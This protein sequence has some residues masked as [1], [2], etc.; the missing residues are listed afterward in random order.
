MESPATTQAADTGRDG[1]RPRPGPI[2]PGERA[3]R[4]ERDVPNRRRRGAPVRAHRVRGR[5]DALPAPAPAQRQS[6]ATERAE[7][8]SRIL[9]SLSRPSRST[10]ISTETLS[11]ESRFTTLGRG[12][13]S[14]PGSSTTSLGSPRIVVVHGAM[15]VRPRRGMAASRLSTTTGRRPMSGSSH[16]QSSPRRGDPFTTMRPRLGMKPGRPTR[17]A[18]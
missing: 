14:A 17:L 9:S 11:T 12:T 2:P 5:Q 4:R 18:R 15:R 16:H 13:G 6:T 7:Q 10:R 8:I 3:E 1:T